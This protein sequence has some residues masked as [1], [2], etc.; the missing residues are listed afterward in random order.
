MVFKFLSKELGV[1]HLFSE[2]RTLI[3]AV[4]FAVPAIYVCATFSVQRMFLI[5]VYE[6][7]IN[8]QY[9]KGFFYLT[10][11]LINVDLPIK[12]IREIK[13]K[14]TMILGQWFLLQYIH[15]L[16][17]CMKDRR[18]YTITSFIW[19][20]GFKKISQ[21]LNELLDQ[22][23]KQ[24]RIRARDKCAEHLYN[25]I[26]L[27]ISGDMENAKNTFISAVR[28]LAEYIHSQ[29]GAIETPIEPYREPAN[30]YFDVTLL[31]DSPTERVD[32]SQDSDNKAIDYDNEAV[33]VAVKELGEMLKKGVIDN[34]LLDKLF[35]GTAK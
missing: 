18:T 14:P 5:T 7:Y 19:K 13:Y 15:D 28:I 29:V 30:N 25:A 3:A 35:S 12:D 21:E 32:N 10:E 23:P 16:T 31:R 11:K 33:V 1:Y 34:E 17:F 2:H 8:V 22:Y 9:H 24:Q 6:D 20:I 4:F 27:K 26:V